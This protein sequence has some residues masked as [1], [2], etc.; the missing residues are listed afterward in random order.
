VN[1]AIIAFLLCALAGI[2]PASG[3]QYSGSILI[4]AGYF[5]YARADAMLGSS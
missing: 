1:S 2:D 3:L 4:C 5:Y